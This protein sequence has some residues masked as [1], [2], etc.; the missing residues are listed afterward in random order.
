MPWFARVSALSLLL[1]SPH[2]A[3]R[4]T[5]H[6]NCL[7]LNMSSRNRVSL[8]RPRLYRIK[9]VNIDSYESTTRPVRSQLHQRE[10][11]LTTYQAASGESMR[12]T[13]HANNTY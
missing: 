11:Q 5:K 7:S 4:S 2:L 12:T 13:L 9:P 3:V 10:E 6:K 1:S 8:S